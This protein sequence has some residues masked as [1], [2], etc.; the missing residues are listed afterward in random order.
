MSG[1]QVQEKGWK[2]VPIGGLI[3]RAGSAEEYETGDWRTYRPVWDPAKCIHCLRCWIF[4][5]DSAIQAKDGKMTGI[6]YK[7]CKGCGICAAECPAKVHAIEMILES[8]AEKGE[9]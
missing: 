8:E 5:P 3:T 6:D 7:H 4:C 1:G 2:D 9:K